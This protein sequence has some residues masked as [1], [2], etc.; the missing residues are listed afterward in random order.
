MALVNMP[1]DLAT[2]AAMGDRL[3][4]HAIFDTLDEPVL[5]IDRGFHVVAINAAA[6]SRYPWS[7]EP[8][9][10]YCY[11]LTHASGAPC[12][13]PQVDCPVR[14]VFETGVRA[15]VVHTHGGR[16]G[17]TR[18]E[19]VVASPLR[20]REGRLAHVIEEI[21]E[22]S[23]GAHDV[24]ARLQRELVELH[25]LLPICAACKRIRDDQGAWIAIDQYV[26]DHSS[27]HFTHGL[28]PTCANELYP[29]LTRR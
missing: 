11:S 27:A 13:E 3:A 26:S 22:L 24:I 1:P 29:G 25:G 28:C 10:P 2:W 5:I 20:D 15:R 8:S 7:S 12:C 18:I 14:M 4:P 17:A 9:P 23:A 21:R 6:R 19:E 16:D